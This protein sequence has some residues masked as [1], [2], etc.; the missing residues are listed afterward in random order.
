MIETD[1]LLKSELCECL[2]DFI[3][4]QNMELETTDIQNCS[5]NVKKSTNSNKRRN[6]RRGNTKKR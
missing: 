2:E 3:V 4:Y 6:N 1:I 5:H